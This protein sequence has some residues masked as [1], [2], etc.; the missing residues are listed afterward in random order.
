M[1]G[2]VLAQIPKRLEPFASIDAKFLAALPD[3][4]VF[5]LVAAFAYLIGSISTSAL[6]LEAAPD[7]GRRFEQAGYELEN[8]DCGGYA[9]QCG[10]HAK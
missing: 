1:I 6:Y 7:G 4:P 9:D 3:P 10:H 5:S 2:I 8:V